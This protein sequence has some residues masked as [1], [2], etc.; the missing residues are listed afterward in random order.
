MESSAVI[1]MNE[2]YKKITGEEVYLYASSPRGG[3]LYVFANAQ[4]PN[5]GAAE[6][7][8]RLM[9]EAAHKGMSHQDIVSKF[10]MLASRR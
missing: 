7:H 9:L 4:I 10:K 3:T 1:A 5:H 2:E 8:M 6:R